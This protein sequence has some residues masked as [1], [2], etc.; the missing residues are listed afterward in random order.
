MICFTMKHIKTLVKQ[1]ILDNI[2]ISVSICVISILQLRNSWCLFTTLAANQYLLSLKQYFTVFGTL[3]Y[4]ALYF[5]TALLQFL[6]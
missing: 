3:S 5:T 1:I 2:D 6:H 4:I